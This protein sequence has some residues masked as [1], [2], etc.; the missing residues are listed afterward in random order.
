MLVV[1]VGCSPHFKQGGEAGFWRTCFS[2]AAQNA[3][4]ALQTS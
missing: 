2:M 1:K 4:T 3:E